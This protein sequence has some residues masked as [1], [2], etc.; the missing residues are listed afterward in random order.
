MAAVIMAAHPRSAANMPLEEAI[1]TRHASRAYL[2]TPVPSSVLQRALALAT[3]APSNS[4]VQPWRLWILSGQPLANLKTE[5]MKHA[6][7]GEEP[8][9]PPLPAWANKFRSQVGSLVYGEGW[10]I[11]RNNSEGRRQAVLRNFEFF[12]APMGC[13]VAMKADLDKA[14]SLS[15]GMYLQT[16]ALALGAEGVG[17]C[18]QVSIA[19][20]P[21]VVKEVVGIPEDFVVICGMAVGFEDPDAKVNTIRPGRLGWEETTVIL[22]D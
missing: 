1:T 13:I 14:D 11:S 9:I 2:P 6:S 16:L 4:N 19:G 17:T 22:S 10:G 18:L 8:H 7:A 20:Y 5:L 12:G 15:V 3:H 21:E